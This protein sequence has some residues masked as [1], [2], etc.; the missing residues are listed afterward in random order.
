MKNLFLI[1]LALLVCTCN[2]KEKKCFKIFTYSKGNISTSY[3]LKINDSDTVYYLNRYPYEQNDLH[4]FLLIKNEKERLNDLICKLKFPL[5]DSLFLN[6]NVEDGTTIGFSIDNKR[7]ILH[8]EDG[9]KEFWRF[10]KW[11]DSLIISK[12]LNPTKR[13]I[14]TIEF[15][16]MLRLPPPSIIK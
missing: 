6:K 12:Q 10:E 11:M 2:E 8:A 4:Y 3:L 1:T 9:P 5:K 15:D 7:I 14:K 16:T 13:K